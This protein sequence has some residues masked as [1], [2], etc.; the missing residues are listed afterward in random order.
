MVLFCRGAILA[1][2]SAAT[3]RH[4]L[5]ARQPT[6]TLLAQLAEHLGLPRQL[7][8]LLR[9]H[10]PLCV[11][12][13]ALRASNFRQLLWYPFDLL[14][15]SRLSPPHRIIATA[16]LR[17]SLHRDPEDISTALKVLRA[18]GELDTLQRG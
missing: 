18:G 12:D 14:Q 13:G 10:S 5:L 15:V 1:G 16:V 7:L 9:L 2:E 11:L 17:S 8:R 4:Q 3:L 6:G